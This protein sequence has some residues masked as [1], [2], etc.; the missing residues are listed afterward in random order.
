M[1]EF[2]VTTVIAGL[3]VE[4][5]CKE[6]HNCSLLAYVCYTSSTWER[7]GGAIADGDFDGCYLGLLG[8]VG[9]VGLLVTPESDAS[10]T[11]VRSGWRSFG[12]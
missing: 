5:A 4:I 6:F 12:G 2:V 3:I 8:E 1:C 7:K 11:G 10:R 9:D